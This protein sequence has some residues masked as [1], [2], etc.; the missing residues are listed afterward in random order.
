MLMFH[1]AAPHIFA[2][3][4]K[5]PYVK[6]ALWTGRWELCSITHVPGNNGGV[7][8]SQTLFGIFNLI[9]GF[10][11]WF[12]CFLEKGDPSLCL[13]LVHRLF[14]KELKSEGWVLTF[15]TI[16]LRDSSSTGFLWHP[17]PLNR[18]LLSLVSFQWWPANWWNIEEYGM[19]FR[20][21]IPNNS[22]LIGFSFLIM[23]F[24]F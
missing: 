8:T 17:N 1:S 14:L 19:N 2:Y 12:S 5:P 9:E 10:S 16:W 24:S 15:V 23:V 22:F 6:Q 4:L 18:Q 3:V 21:V 7:F 13:I 20:P 11:I